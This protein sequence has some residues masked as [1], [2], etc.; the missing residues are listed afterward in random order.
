MSRVQG[1]EHLDPRP[2]LVLLVCGHWR[3]LGERP[4]HRTVDCGRSPACRS[5][6]GPR[7]RPVVAIID[8]GTGA[9]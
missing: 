6:D 7:K 8:L 9:R 2:W 4:P 3:Q 5:T 1:T